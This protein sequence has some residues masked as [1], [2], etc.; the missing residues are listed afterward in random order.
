MP[1]A[2]RSGRVRWRRHGFSS[3]IPRRHV[4]NN[5]PRDNAPLATTEPLWL[6][7][8][9]GS[10]PPAAPWMMIGGRRGILRPLPL[11]SIRETILS[12]PSTIVEVLLCLVPSRFRSGRICLAQFVSPSASG[13]STM[14]SGRVAAAGHSP[15][16]CSQPPDT[17]CLATARS[18]FSGRRPPRRRRSTRSMSPSMVCAG[19]LN[20]SFK[21]GANPHTSKAG[22]RRFGSVRTPACG[23][24]STTSRPR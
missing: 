10:L 8:R 2:S 20:P 11:S 17:A 22:D 18:T 15:C 12:F 9:H 21:V 16:S 1:S 4:G 5:S 13:C 23:S 19:S 14:R 7:V 24:I 3:R 6:A